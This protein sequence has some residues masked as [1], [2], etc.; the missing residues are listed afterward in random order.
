MPEEKLAF[1]GITHLRC[2]PALHRTHTTHWFYTTHTHRTAHILHI[3]ILHRLS[4]FYSGHVAFK[5]CANSVL[6]R[7]M[8]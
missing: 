5:R 1:H 6:P 4:Q 7:V 2:T 8:P 3:T